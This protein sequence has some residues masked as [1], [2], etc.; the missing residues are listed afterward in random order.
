[1]FSRKLEVPVCYGRGDTTSP[2]GMAENGCDDCKLYIECH[3]IGKE[4]EKGKS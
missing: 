2:V 1:M 3:R 4:N